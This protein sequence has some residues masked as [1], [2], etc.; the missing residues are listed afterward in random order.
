M[1]RDRAVFDEV[2][3]LVNDVASFATN[4]ANR[5][6]EFIDRLPSPERLMQMA[7]DFIKEKLLSDDGLCLAPSCGG[8]HINSGEEKDLVPGSN[9]LEIL[10]SHPTTH[11]DRPHATRYNRAHAFDLAQMF[12]TH[13]CP[14]KP[15]L[16]RPLTSPDHS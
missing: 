5:L 11:T 2:E 16:S 10:A 6:T 13:H 1:L 7:G 4:L 15:P 9:D 14:H 3:E 8:T 12:L